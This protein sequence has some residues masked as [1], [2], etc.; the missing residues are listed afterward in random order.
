MPE[1][2]RFVELVRAGLLALLEALA[3]LLLLCVGTGVP[4]AASLLFT[5]SCSLCMISEWE[6]SVLVMDAE[7]RSACDKEERE[8]RLFCDAP[9]LDVF[10]ETGVESSSICI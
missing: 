7:R 2:L 8:D 4:L 10:L 3:G 5:L 6:R 9:D 1:A